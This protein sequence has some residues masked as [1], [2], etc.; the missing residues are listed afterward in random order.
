M[1]KRVALSLYEARA[2]EEDEYPTKHY[3]NR[4]YF[5][6]AS[7]NEKGWNRGDNWFAFSP[8]GGTVRVYSPYG[9]QS[10]E[11]VIY[12]DFAQDLGELPV[13]VN[14]YF[15]VRGV[16]SQCPVRGS[17]KTVNVQDPWSG[18]AERCFTL[19]CF[20]LSDEALW[21]L[22]REDRLAQIGGMKEQEEF[23]VENARQAY[24]RSLV[25]QANRMEIVG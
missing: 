13:V 14:A 8:K 24:R 4:I 12:Q 18:K 15:A 22:S 9:E 10:D 25:N 2:V 19:N 5:H 11:D 7:D 16:A 21:N 17:Y 6:K 20:H 23:E 1:E 3:G